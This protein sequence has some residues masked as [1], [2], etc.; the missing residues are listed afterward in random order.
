MPHHDGRV[1]T[2]YATTYDIDRGPCHVLGGTPAWHNV[3]RQCQQPG[4]DFAAGARLA[5]V[6]ELSARFEPGNYHDLD[7]HA[8]ANRLGSLCQTQ[9]RALDSRIFHATLQPLVFVIE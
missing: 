8:A 3:A 2:A 7:Q 1:H 9:N 6:V 5:S 4:A